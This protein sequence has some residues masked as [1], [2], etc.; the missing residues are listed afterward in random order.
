MIDTDLSF[1]RSEVETVITTLVISIK[2]P[3]N[4]VI[5]RNLGK[6]KRRSMS[7]AIFSAVKF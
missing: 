6:C 5:I 4:G 3:F 1:E 2:N 7:R